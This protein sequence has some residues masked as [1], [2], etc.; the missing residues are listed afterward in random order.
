MA[1]RAALSEELERERIGRMGTKAEQE[2][3]MARLRRERDAVS[4]EMD[5]VIGERD[6]LLAEKSQVMMERD[7]FEAECGEVRS[8]LD[9]TVSLAGELE[10]ERNEERAR[11]AHLQDELEEMSSLYQKTREDC[12]KA[13]ED[14][15]KARGELERLEGEAVSR[16]REGESES[17]RLILELECMTKE[18]NTLSDELRVAR[19]N[20]DQRGREGERGGGQDEDLGDGTSAADEDVRVFQSEMTAVMTM[21]GGHG[22]DGSK[23]VGRAVGEGGGERGVLATSESGRAEAERMRLAV[24]KMKMTA[25][26]DL[27]QGGLLSDLAQRTNETVRRGRE[28][29]RKS[30][31]RCKASLE[32]VSQFLL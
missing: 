8:M 31:A 11:V 1:S 9:A 12:E 28:E 27:A 10:E 4:A 24:E 18:R 5:A 23:E 15:E 20:A 14:C 19:L 26:R 17:S 13:R 32:Q 2:E 16:A 22:N 25:E 3:E 21:M 30:L 6:A 7:G 29:A